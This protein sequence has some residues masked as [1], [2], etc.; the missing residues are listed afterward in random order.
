MG[1]EY[2]DELKE[3]LPEYMDILEEQGEIENRGDGYYT[4]PFCGSGDKKNYT[5]AF[6]INRTSFHCFSCGEHGDIFDLVAYIEDLP[7]DWKRHYN[8]T[9]KIMRPYLEGNVVKEKKTISV[10]ETREEDYTDYLLQCH[11]NVYKTDY[12]HSRGLSTET[13]GRFQLGFDE[14]KNLVTIPYN[15]DYKGY[16]HRIL[17]DSDNK[18]CKHGNEIFNINAL[19]SDNNKY[20]FVTEGQI[21]AM[22]FEEIGCYAIGLGGVNEV[23][24][25]VNLLKQKPCDKILVLALDNDKAGRKATGKLIEEIAEAEIGQNYIL[26]SR[27]YGE[28]KD[29][30]EYLIADRERFTKKMSVFKK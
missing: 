8:R 26:N 28:Y 15:P 23:A 22:S 10:P 19:Y 6:H 30:N 13:I 17:W 21:D 3:L 9:L 25:L 27:L 1:F 20:L 11:E 29:A 4:C 2:K 12:F 7:D 24:K 16:V 14:D 5:A 18:Y